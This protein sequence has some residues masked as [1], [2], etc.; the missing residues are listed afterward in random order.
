MYTWGAFFVTGVYLYSILFISSNKRS[1]LIFLMLFSL[2]AAYT[3]Y[4]GLIAAL[5]ANVFVLVFL[6][7]RKNNNWRI[8]LGYSCITILIYLPWLFIL[9]S[10]MTEVQKYFWVPAITWQTILSCFIDPFAQKFWMTPYSWVMVFIIYSLTI[11]VLY[12]NYIVR[13]DQQGIALG[14][15]LFIFGSTVLNTA[16]ISLLSQPI[17]YT[18]YITNI[19]IMLLVAPTLFFIAVKNNWVK[20]VLLTVLL[21][22]GFIVSIGESYFSYGPYKQSVEYLRKTYPDV[23]KV[24]HVIEITAGPFVEYGNSDI[25]NYWYKPEKTI[26]FTNMA[27]F[28]NLHTT[29]SLCKVLKKDEPFCVVSPSNL[30]INFN[31]NNLK[32]ILSESQIVKVDTVA[33]N[34]AEAGRKILFLLYILKYQDTKATINSGLYR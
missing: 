27:V 7:V 6:F 19:V 32:R 28:I 24:F 22:C 34:K 13:K 9:L 17:L 15:S 12:R 31:G 11:W 3:H 30:P 10:Q 25:E 33:D 20:C 1:D 2:M 29:D 8:H 21:C 16:V 23:K 18:R 4:Y 14:L 5:W 26:V